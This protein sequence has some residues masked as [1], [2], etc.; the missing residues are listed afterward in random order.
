[1]RIRTLRKIE[2]VSSADPSAET[3]RQLPTPPPRFPL[4]FRHVTA[5]NEDAFSE[6]DTLSRTRYEIIEVLGGL[7]TYMA[8]EVPLRLVA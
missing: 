4:H 1:M 2:S 3:K 6:G 7:G 8:E 5:P